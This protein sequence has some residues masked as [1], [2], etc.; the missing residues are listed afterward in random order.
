MRELERTER[1]DRARRIAASWQLDASQECAIV[2]GSTARGWS[3]HSSD[4]D[5]A[6]ISPFKMRGDLEYIAD[7]SV[8][9]LDLSMVEFLL[10]L[11]TLDLIQLRVLSNLASGIP[12][13]GGHTICR[14]AFERNQSAVLSADITSFYLE[15]AASCAKKLVD[16]DTIQRLFALNQSIQS[17][18]L[19]ACAATTFRLL[20]LKWAMYVLQKEA[21]RTYYLCTRI[22]NALGRSPAYRELCEALML[23]TA[24]RADRS[25]D[26][27]FPLSNILTQIAAVRTSTQLPPSTLA[28]LELTMLSGALHN[29]NS[30][31]I[32]DLAISWGDLHADVQALIGEAAGMHSSRQATIRI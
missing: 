17:C 12:I 13:V 7:I 6:V 28:F 32:A 23:S 26:E 1:L 24:E 31:E 30:G 19:L 16:G 25:D 14:Q 4:I 8:T 9:Y 5:I 27:H 20:K 11:D 22:F 18:V 15:I 29:I 2:I 10:G 21:P 3:E